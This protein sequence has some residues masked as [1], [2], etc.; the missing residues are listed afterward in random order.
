MIDD[1]RLEWRG[2]GLQFQSELLNCC[3]HR[4]A[5]NVGDGP[6]GWKRSRVVESPFNL[7]IVESGQA[8][9]SKTGRET[10]CL[11]L[12]SCSTR[13]ANATCVAR[14]RNS[15]PA[16][17]VSDS[18]ASGALSFNFGPPLAMT[19]LNTVKLVRKGN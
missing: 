2:A 16:R 8:V 18:L 12:T 3:E 17:I 1:E 7:E 15:C 4:W 9:R 10:P 5:G 13:A 19:R 14:I 11:L 6:V